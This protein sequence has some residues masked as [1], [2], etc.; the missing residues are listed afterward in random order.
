MS[1]VVF[2][3]YS[4]NWNKW[5]VEFFCFQMWH[6]F[7]NGSHQEPVAAERMPKLDS[8]GE[9]EVQKQVYNNGY[10][11]SYIDSCTYQSAY[12]AYMEDA[13][14][15]TAAEGMSPDYP[16]QQPPI[17]EEQLDLSLKNSVKCEPDSSTGNL[18]ITQ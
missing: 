13:I 8:R 12:N 17:V 10:N 3:I 7:H 6:D 15:R 4:Y 16:H 5:D 18:I 2:E 1:V 9:D 11:G 14:K